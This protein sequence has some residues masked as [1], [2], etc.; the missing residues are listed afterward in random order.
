MNSNFNEL[1]NIFFDIYSNIKLIQLKHNVEINPKNI[2]ENKLI[3]LYN[4]LNIFYNK[5][6][7][8]KNNHILLQGFIDYNYV[9][10]KEVKYFLLSIKTTKSRSIH[11]KI[12]TKILKL[13]NFIP[14][15]IT[16]V[17]KDFIEGITYFS[18]ELENKIKI[19]IYHRAASCGNSSE[20][21]KKKYFDCYNTN[22]SEEI[23]IKK[24]HISK[25]YLE[26]LIYDDMFRTLSLHFPSTLN[27]QNLKQNNRH[28]F[29]LSE[30]AKN[31]N[32]CF[33][34]I[35]IIIEMEYDNNFPIILKIN[36]INDNKIIKKEIFMKTTYIDKY[37][38]TRYENDVFHKIFENN[39]EDI[40]IQKFIVS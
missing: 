6:Y 2:N 40:I 27:N 29:Q 37:G 26:R 33:L 9:K 32:K 5:L 22:T 21:F 10:I 1:T 7:N 31:Y 38:I 36:Y 15:G 4:N 11:D 12:F 17:F 28:L 39:K 14:L 35:N 25:C 3:D 20:D 23:E 30:R 16:Q 19:P 34:G 18:D 8:I 24:K 13:N